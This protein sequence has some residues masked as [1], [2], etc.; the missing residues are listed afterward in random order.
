MHAT[1]NGP[2]AAGLLS[3][4]PAPLWLGPKD[5]SLRIFLGEDDTGFLV[6]GRHVS[7]SVVF[8]RLFKFALEDATGLFLVCGRHDSSS[9]EAFLRLFAFA[10]VVRAAL[11]DD[12]SGIA[13]CG[14]GA[15]ASSSSSTFIGLLTVLLVGGW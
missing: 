8:L 4:P 1:A 15:A 5:D 12:G 10:R 9:S 13:R 11:C 2:T 3:P 6:C 14:A 7:S